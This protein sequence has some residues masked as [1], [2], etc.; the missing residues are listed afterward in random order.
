[1][2]TIQTI[3][4]P[5]D[6]SYTAQDLTMAIDVLPNL[7]GRLNQENLF[8]SEGVSTTLVE[9]RFRNGYIT[10]LPV[11]DRDGAPSV[12][13]GPDENAVYLEVPHIP[14]LD[15]LTPKD[16]QDMFAFTANPLRK[17]TMED[18]M[19][20]KLQAIR[21]KHAITLEYFRMGALKGLIKD[22]EG[23]ILH[24]LFERFGI[25]KKTVDFELDNVATDVKAKCREV[26][27]YQSKNLKGEIKSG[28]RV[29]VDP[30]F[31][32]SLTG[33]P[34]VEKFFVN[35]VEARSLAVDDVTEF[36]FGGLIFEEYDATVSLMDGTTD[37]LVAEGYG[38][39]YPTGTMNAFRTFNGPA[40]N[41]NMVNMP[42]AEIYVSP[43]E[44]DHGAG[45]ELKSESNPLPVVSRPDLLVEC[46]QY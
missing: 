43:K 26:R 3:N 38:H 40:N 25:V 24:D 42:G 4:G 35:Y 20:E 29:K 5:V 6:F 27:R 34:N 44:L 33:H 32:D 30:E 16:L 14:H 12:G 19:T 22:G 17:K 23:S 7:Y 36:P 1:M 13:K 9:V 21:N 10:V 46:V 11:R 8:P 18:A 31:F 2:T 41:I 45:V 39:A 28:T 15:Y 37:D